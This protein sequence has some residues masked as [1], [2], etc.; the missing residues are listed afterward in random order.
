MTVFAVNTV[1]K[2]LDLGIPEV[3]L[4]V[5]T[6]TLHRRSRGLA[7]IV[8]VLAL[9][10]LA[11]AL[12]TLASQTAIQRKQYQSAYADHQQCNEL[13]EFGERILKFRIAENTSYSGETVQLEL[14]WSTNPSNMSIPYVGEIAFHR[15]AD[16]DTRDS[17]RITVKGGLRSSAILEAAKTIR[18]SH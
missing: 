6:S 9:G 15:I 7:A 16:Q 2:E 4:R 8:M 17:W 3:S 11:L 10:G 12:L 18:I 1:S 13:L 5:Q 14:P